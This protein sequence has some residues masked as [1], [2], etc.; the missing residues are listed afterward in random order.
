VWPTAAP[1]VG[2]AEELEH[3]FK[4]ALS[5]DTATVIVVSTKPQKAVL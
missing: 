4:A 3:E 5:A 1:D 2:T